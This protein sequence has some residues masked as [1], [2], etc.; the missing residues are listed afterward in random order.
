VQIQIDEQTKYYGMQ[1]TDYE[2]V[3]CRVK[4]SKAIIKVVLMQVLV[5]RTSRWWNWRDGLQDM[6]V[7]ADIQILRIGELC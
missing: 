1:P 3:R 6:V 2:A 7:L 4:V 5:L